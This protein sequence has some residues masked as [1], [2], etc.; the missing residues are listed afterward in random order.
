MIN[1]NFKKAPDMEGKDRLDERYIGCRRS[2][3]GLM[4]AQRVKKNWD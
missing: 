2:G 3:L 4:L 1:R